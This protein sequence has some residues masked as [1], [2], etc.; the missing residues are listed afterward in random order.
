MRL[1]SHDREFDIPYEEVCIRVVQQNKEEL[2]I[3]AYKLGEKASHMLLGVYKSAERA[4]E[5]M[6][7][8]RDSY[9]NL[10]Q[11]ELNT[12]NSSELPKYYFEFPEE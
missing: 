12:S 11:F 10:K 9:N 2:A 1:I 5:I 6:E 8:L 4:E 3:R 7:E